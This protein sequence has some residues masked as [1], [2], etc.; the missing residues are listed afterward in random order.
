MKYLQALQK[1]R[2]E[3]SNSNG[4]NG[5]HADPLAV[6]VEEFGIG[7]PG[8]SFRHKRLEAVAPASPYEPARTTQEVPSGSFLA[9][10]S[11]VPEITVDPLSADVHAV[12]VTNPQSIYCEEY[13]N[14]RTH[15]LRKSQL[16]DLQ[17]IVIASVGVGE[18]KSITALNLSWLLAQTEGVKALLIDCDLRRPSLSTYF[19]L[20]LKGG[21]SNVLDGTGRLTDSIVRLN[22]AGL[23]LLP[24]GRARTDVAE[25]ISGSLF[26]QVLEEARGIFDY[27]IIDAPPLGVFTD[28]A[29][30]INQA[31]GAI[32]VVAANQTSYKDI[33]RVL[34][35]IPR[36]R[37]LGA[38]L[39]RSDESLIDS[40]YYDY[41]NYSAR[42]AD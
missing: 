31:D 28:A 41:P 10:L 3:G 36:E 12:A 1:A 39:N 25:L 20:N 6:A 34:E 4:S 2:S 5:G 42:T 18:G 37:V 29:V 16:D 7:G 32:L 8:S 19:G 13:R 15:L 27:V 35:S 38:V 30:L 22:P 11:R 40:G 33:G 17:T 23:Y 14:L 26:P 9:E 21:L 24:G